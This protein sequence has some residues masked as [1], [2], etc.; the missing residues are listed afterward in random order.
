MKYQK[1]FVIGKIHVDPSFKTL[2]LQCWRDGAMV[3]ACVVLAEELGSVLRTHTVVP[4][5]PAN[6]TASAG[7]LRPQ[8]CTRYNYMPNT[9]HQIMNL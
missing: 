1:A 9:K 4:N 8:A 6:M 2:K 3:K 7:L 5:P